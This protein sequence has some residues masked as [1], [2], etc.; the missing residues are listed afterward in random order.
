[1]IIYLKKF[2]RLLNV[3]QDDDH[4]DTNRE[5]PFSKELWY[6][7]ADLVKKIKDP[8]VSASELELKPDVVL[9]L[10][11]NLRDCVI[12]ENLICDRKLSKDLSEIAK[13][14]T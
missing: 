7:A 13:R 4:H 8:I 6:Q 11:R 12:E 1:M 9:K 10:L 14:Y 3:V 2:L 5:R